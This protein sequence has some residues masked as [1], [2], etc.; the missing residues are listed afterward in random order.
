MIFLD[1]SLNGSW[2]FLKKNTFPQANWSGVKN[3]FDIRV[4]YCYGVNQ[5]GFSLF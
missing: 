1:N 4:N 5:A 3:H 2:W